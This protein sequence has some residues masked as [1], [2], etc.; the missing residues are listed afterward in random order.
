LTIAKRLKTRL[1]EKQNPIKS[2]VGFAD[3]CIAVVFI[4]KEGQKV[5][6]KRSQCFSSA[7]FVAPSSVV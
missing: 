2:G 5:A 7:K 4:T 3:N 6:S 1:S